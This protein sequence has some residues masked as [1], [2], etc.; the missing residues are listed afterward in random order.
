MS[1]GQILLRS[2][3]SSAR[4]DGMIDLSLSSESTLSITT[5]LHFIKH[6]EQAQRGQLNVLR[7]Q[8]QLTKSM[9]Q[10]HTVPG[11]KNNRAEDQYAL[12]HTA[13]AND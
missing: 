8:Q 13:K 12:L 7:W 5:I 6:L 4:M 9:S 3:F 11:L 10:T 1:S 2:S